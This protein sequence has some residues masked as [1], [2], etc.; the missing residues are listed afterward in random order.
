MTT[1]L[2]K[3]KRINLKRS[4]DRKQEE[5]NMKFKNEGLSDEIIMEQIILNKKRNKHNISDDNEKLYKR[6]V[7]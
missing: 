1:F 2:E 4:I 5:I 6:W 3:I 7:Q